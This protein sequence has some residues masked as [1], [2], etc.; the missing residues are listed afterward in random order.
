[1]TSNEEFFLEEDKL[2]AELAEARKPIDQKWTD[3]CRAFCRQN[4]PL[5][6]GSAYTLKSRRKRKQETDRFLVTDFS[7]S[8]PFPR[9]AVI[10]AE[11]FWLD[12]EGRKVGLTASYPVWG[13]L[14]PPV[15][16]ISKNQYWERPKLSQNDTCNLPS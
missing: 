11:G 7:M 16:E 3:L 14:S 15:F 6:I 9:R 12:D 5:K 10:Y 8:F 2:K 1:M 4:S 13:V